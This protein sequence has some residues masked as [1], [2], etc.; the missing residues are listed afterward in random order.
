M[1]PSFN[2]AF[3]N[4][5]PVDETLHVGGECDHPIESY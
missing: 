4:S 3:T 1:L 2:K 5:E